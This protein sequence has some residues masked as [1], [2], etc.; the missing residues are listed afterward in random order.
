MRP[1]RPVVIR[2]VADGLLVSPTDGEI[3]LPPDEKSSSAVEGAASEW[4]GYLAIWDG[5]DAPEG[6]V[7]IWIRGSAQSDVPSDEGEMRMP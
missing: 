7:E 5:E 1:I 2:R 6:E 4:R 3:A